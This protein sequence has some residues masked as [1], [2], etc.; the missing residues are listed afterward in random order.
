MDRFV[1]ARSSIRAAPR[2]LALG[3]ALVVSMIFL[4]VLTLIAVAVIR[5]TGLGARMT[6]N[7]SVSNEAQE[8]S[9]TIR[10]LTEV[11]VEGN[12]Y[13]RGWPCSISTGSAT[14]GGSPPIY[15]VL[16]S[17]WSLPLPTGMAVLR[18]GQSLCT[19]TPDTSQPYKMWFDA[20]DESGSFNPVWYKDDTTGV[21]DDACYSRN[22]A[23]TGVT[24]YT[25]AGNISVYKLRADI[26]PGSGG[27]M[28]SGYEGTGRGAA[29]G[30]GY[31]FFF[32]QSEGQDP[33]NLA[34]N[35]TGSVYRFLIRN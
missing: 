19:D 6:A 18:Q 5:T 3:F 16:D 30:G 7:N 33:S 1:P 11:M 14:C 17:E 20:N 26:A 15:S 24:A 2:G 35:Q 32:T 23:G 29:G 28:V 31:I 4:V 27:A 25:V 8:V 21:K 10:S 13:Y 12:A 22:I 34:Q 9:E